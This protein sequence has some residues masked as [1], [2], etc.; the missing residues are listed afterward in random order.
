M[1]YWKTFVFVSALWAA[2]EIYQAIRWKSS[3]EYSRDRGSQWLLWIVIF[4]SLAAGIPVA[5][6][7]Y[8]H[9]R[10][11]PRT[12]SILGISLIAVGIVIKTMAIA[13]LK[14]YFTTNVAL[15]PGHKLI[16]TGLY[17]YVRHPA[18]AGS[19]ISFLGLGLGFSNWITLL[20]IFFPVTLSFLHRIKIE[21]RVLMEKFG[22]EY[23][24][25]RKSTKALL[26]WIF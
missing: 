18:Y 15:L 25:Y 2:G 14:N 3:R 6:S 4:F 23:E 8:G 5:F 13:T 24:E 16:K 17:R 21:E 7:G 12:L 9:L 22:Q 1:F 10:R 11:C 19:I 26:P 20:I